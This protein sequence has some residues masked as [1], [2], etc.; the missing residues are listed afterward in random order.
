M[1]YVPNPYH[2]GQNFGVFVSP[3]EARQGAE[4]KLHVKTQRTA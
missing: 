4:K 1:Y 2:C 3:I